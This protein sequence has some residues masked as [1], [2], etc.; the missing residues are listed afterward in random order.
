MALTDVQDIYMLSS[1]TGQKVPNTSQRER[2][3]QSSR[4]THRADK[5]YTSRRQHAASRRDTHCRATQRVQATSGR[6]MHRMLFRVPLAHGTAADSA[7]EAALTKIAAPA[8][9]AQTPAASE[10]ATGLHPAQDHVAALAQCV[11]S[12]A[13]ALVSHNTMQS[14]S[15]LDHAHQDAAHA[16]DNLP[17][18]FQHYPPASSSAGLTTRRADND[19][20]MSASLLR[21]LHQLAPTSA[22]KLTATMQRSSLKLPSEAHQRT[23]RLAAHRSL[24]MLQAFC[25]ADVSA[26]LLSRQHR[27]TAG[28]TQRAAEALQRGTR[29]T[30][31]L[32]CCHCMLTDSYCCLSNLAMKPDVVACRRAAMQRVGSSGRL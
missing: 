4:H 5:T 11:T 3:H 20:T 27:F 19:Q 13:N 24:F 14:S 30:C 32:I 29:C 16:E 26:S 21:R 7:G 18:L 10:V 8:A 23:V 2:E 31:V 1:C 17:E 28:S 9:A 25:R 12:L 15:R 22:A 6:S